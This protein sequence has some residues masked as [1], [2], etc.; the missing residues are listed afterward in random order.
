MPQDQGWHVTTQGPTPV[1]MN[2][3]SLST[4]LNR[5]GQPEINPF[6]N[7]SGQN[8]WH[9]SFIATSQTDQLELWNA[10]G[11]GPLGG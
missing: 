6:K 4:Q 9:D 3:S 1:Q 7:W 2:V 8:T 10:T 11:L 5:V